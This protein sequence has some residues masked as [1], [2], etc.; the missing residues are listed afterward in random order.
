M[1]AA[2][3]VGQP[4]RFGLGQPAWIAVLVEPSTVG[5]QRHRPRRVVRIPLGGSRFAVDGFRQFADVGAFEDEPR[6]Q[7]NP[8][9][10]RGLHYRQRHDAVQAQLQEVRGD[11][12]PGLV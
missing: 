3:V 11:V 12:D 4:N 1:L 2:Y 6:A 9:C 10:P 8:A 5:Q 7:R